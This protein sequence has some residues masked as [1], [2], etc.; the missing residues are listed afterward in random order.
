MTTEHPQCLNT[1]NGTTETST[2]EEEIKNQTQVILQYSQLPISALRCAHRVLSEKR[3]A[4]DCVQAGVLEHA[5]VILKIAAYQPMLAY[6]CLRVIFGTMFLYGGD[7]LVRVAQIRRLQVSS[8]SSNQDVEKLFYDPETDWGI[9]EL[10]LLEQGLSPTKSTIAYTDPTNPEWRLIVPPQVERN[11]T[12]PR[13]WEVLKMEKSIR[14]L[15]E[16]VRLLLSNS[17]NLR[18]IRLQRI[19]LAFLAF[20]AI[21]RIAIPSLFRRLDVPIDPDTQEPREEDHS[22]NEPDNEAPDI[23]SAPDDQVS[24][25]AARAGPLRR[26]RSIWEAFKRS[27]KREEKQGGFGRERKPDPTSIIDIV[28]R[29]ITNLRHDQDCFDEV[30]F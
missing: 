11:C 6:E 17:R 14:E 13:I 25:A 9:T 16:G 10:Q 5:Q 3:A 19:G 18:N 1:L 24:G 20:V 26:R 27:E 22:Q 4:E 12:E 7:S 8:E 28:S 2:S 29:T 21:E 30:R 15:T 23:I